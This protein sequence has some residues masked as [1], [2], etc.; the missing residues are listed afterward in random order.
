MNNTEL[1]NPIKSIDE[2][3]STIESKYIDIELSKRCNTIFTI[4][5]PDV[6]EKP[7]IEKAS[8]IVYGKSIGILTYEDACN[9]LKIKL[10][11]FNKLTKDEIAYKKLKII[12]EAINDGWK[13]NWNNPNEYKY[14]PVF[15][16]R[17]GFSFDDSSNSWDNTDSVVGSRLCFKDRDLC[18]YCGRMFID[19]YRDYMTYE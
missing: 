1:I 9:K 3:V 6:S 13:P 7:K 17:N 18:E 19:L 12:V 14:Y 15:D 10:S 8:L 4:I 16:M 11:S 5:S 2:W